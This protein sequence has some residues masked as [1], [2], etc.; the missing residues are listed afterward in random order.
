MHVAGVNP[1]LRVQLEGYEVLGRGMRCSG[2]VER[3]HRCQWGGGKGSGVE[4][5]G[6]EVLE[7]A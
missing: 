4:V 7:R 5:W 6:A 3:A 2:G 1:V